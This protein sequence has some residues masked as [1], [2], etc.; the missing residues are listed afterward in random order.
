MSVN[1]IND[2]LPAGWGFRPSTTGQHQLGKKTLRLDDR[3]LR[4]F[5]KQQIDAILAHPKFPDDLVLL[6]LPAV[7]QKALS[8][9]SNSKILAVFISPEVGFDTVSAYLSRLFES[10]RVMGRFLPKSGPDRQVQP[11]LLLDQRIAEL[12]KG[13]VSPVQV[14][15]RGG[16][17]YIKYLGWQLFIGQEKLLETRLTDLEMMKR[18]YSLNWETAGI[19]EERF[20]DLLSRISQEV[21]FLKGYAIIMTS[22]SFAGKTVKISSSDGDFDSTIPRFWVWLKSLAFRGKIPAKTMIELDRLF[23]ELIPE[24]NISPKK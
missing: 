12:N 16:L 8:A 10:D 17:Y 2:S 21:L 6:V 19:S 7:E 24:L 3:L 14:E 5:N 22:K 9:K 15:K 18:A 1:A 4:R 11:N 23:A 20:S 13:P